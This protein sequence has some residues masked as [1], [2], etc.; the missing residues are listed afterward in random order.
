MI[1]V[2]IANTT[3]KVRN[4]ADAADELAEAAGLS[5]VVLMTRTPERC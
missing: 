3:A 5:A 4:V 2:A 1:G